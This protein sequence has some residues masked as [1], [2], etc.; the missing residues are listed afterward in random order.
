MKHTF[1]HIFSQTECISPHTAEEYVHGRLSAKD[2]RIVELHIADCNICSDLIEGVEETSKQNIDI[3]QVIGIIDSKIDARIKRETLNIVPPESRVKP[4]G[5]IV[6][7]RIKRSFSIAATLLLLATLGILIRYYATDS[8]IESSAMLD[9]AESSKSALYDSVSETQISDNEEIESLT[10]KSYDDTKLATVA[11]VLNTPE[12]HASDRSEK[13]MFEKESDIISDI[14]TTDV[15]K[16]EAIINE[17]KSATSSNNLLTA[18]NPT[19]GTSTGTI[20]NEDESKTAVAGIEADDEVEQSSFFGVTRS[21]TTDKDKRDAKSN[22]KKIG[23]DRFENQKYDEAADAFEA[24]VEGGE[25]T[26]QEALFY[27]AR[28]LYE[29]K[30]YDTAL[31]RFDELIAKKGNYALESKWYK[32]QTLIK[33]N[34]ISEA[35]AILE[36]IRKSENEFTQKANQ[37]LESLK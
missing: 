2:T 13:P 20:V 14:S 17:N 18:S 11:P 22:L 34:Q 8:L 10:E 24:V 16:T 25:K 9:K 15:S 37:L 12:T 28:S 19:N 27:S 21:L 3:Q 33:L 26:D 5:R 6:S 1:Q 23:K 31:I 4:T 29:K 7:M 35:K 36:D 32:A 30:D